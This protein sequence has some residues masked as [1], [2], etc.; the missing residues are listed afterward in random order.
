MTER[1]LEQRLVATARALDEKAPVFDVARL[2][3]RPQREFRRSVVIIACVVALLCAIAAPAAVSAFEA[4]FDVKR[5][6]ALSSTE[7]GVTPPYA[8]RRVAVETLRVSVPFGVR[9][10]SSLGPPDE[11]RVRDDISGGMSTVVYKDEGLLLSQWRTT[12]IHPRI[13]LVP[14]AGHVEDVQVGP[15]PGLWIEGSAR[16]TFVLTGADGTT[17]RERFEV[18]SGALLWQADGMTFLLQGAG[19]KDV[20]IGLAAKV[21]R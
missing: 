21:A 13:A 9:M 20:A 14:D 16:G 2:Q 4:L 7:P 5:V 3:G 11:A 19:S 12:D 15:H 17:H 8:G 1:E 6:P 10:I 18:S